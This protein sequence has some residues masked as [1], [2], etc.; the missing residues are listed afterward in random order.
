MA[1]TDEEVCLKNNK[2]TKK[3]QK[4][5]GK[6][7]RRR[8][9]YIVGCLFLLLLFAAFGVL[10]ALLLVVGWQEPRVTTSIGTIDGLFDP[11]H[12]IFSFKVFADIIKIK[13]G[14]QIFLL[15]IW[16]FFYY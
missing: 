11:D 15:P 1:S 5:S 10:V 4:S 8:C 9:F 3:H 13:L 12:H 6:R 7:K 14:F 16:G 2:K